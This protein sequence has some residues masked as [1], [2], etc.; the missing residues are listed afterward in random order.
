MLAVLCSAPHPPLGVALLGLLIAVLNGMLH[1]L[2]YILFCSMI[3]LSFWAPSSPSLPDVFHPIH[4]HPNMVS[5]YIVYSPAVESRSFKVDAD[6]RILIFL[7]A[8]PVSSICENILFRP[9]RDLFLETVACWFDMRYVQP[10]YTTG[11]WPDTWTPILNALRSCEFVA[12]FLDGVMG[13]DSGKSARNYRGSVLRFWPLQIRAR[14]MKRD[15]TRRAY[16]PPNWTPPVLADVTGHVLP[17]R[18][19]LLVVPS[20]AS[21]AGSEAASTPPV[22]T[23]SHKASKTSKSVVLP[24]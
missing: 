24:A 17:K 14:F 7:L 20:T 5:T 4:E 15:H 10:V 16:T 1:F 18:K 3:G 22:L 8:L 6:L 9:V 19:R 2:P 23:P 12:E 13:K 21:V 11:I